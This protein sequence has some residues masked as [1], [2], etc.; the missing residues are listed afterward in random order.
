MEGKIS[1]IDEHKGRLKEPPRGLQ[2][3]T[4]VLW[5]YAP[6]SREWSY[7]V[8]IWST[9]FRM[10]LSVFFICGISFSI[11]R[12]SMLT[13]GCGT[14]GSSYMPSV[15]NLAW[16]VELDK[17]DKLCHV[18]G[19]GTAA[20]ARGTTFFGSHCDAGA[21]SWRGRSRSLMSI[22]DG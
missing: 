14:L 6:L 18:R 4:S 22:K 21:M 12:L 13:Q 19:E 7:R 16:L 3:P 17:E 5:P 20:I 8:V 15:N 10:R 1:V 11:C 2:P 9:S